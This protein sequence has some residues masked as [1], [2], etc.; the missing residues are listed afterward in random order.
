[1]RRNHSTPR[2]PRS[3]KPSARPAPRQSCGGDKT[4]WRGMRRARLYH[5]ALH[6]EVAPL[7]P[8]SAQDPSNTEGNGGVAEKKKDSGP[9]PEWTES[10]P[11][12]PT[13]DAPFDDIIDALLDVKS[14]ALREHKRSRKKSQPS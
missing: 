7:G 5:A 13:T 11:R 8:A 14:E 10:K 6:S 2:L 1:M 12:P 3:H 9:T 4:L